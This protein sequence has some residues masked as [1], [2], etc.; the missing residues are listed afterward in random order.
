[1]DDEFYLDHL[2]IVK[3]Q[4]APFQKKSFDYRSRNR[5]GSLWNL[6]IELMVDEFYSDHLKKVQSQNGPC[7]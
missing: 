6:N 2:K 7:L 4:N 5:Q 1:M 3:S